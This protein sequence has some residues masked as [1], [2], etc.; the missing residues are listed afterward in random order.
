MQ[1]FPRLVLKRLQ[2][3]SLY[4]QPSLRNQTNHLFLVTFKQALHLLGQFCSLFCQSSHS[5]HPGIV[6]G[7][8]R[9]YFYGKTGQQKYPILCP[10]PALK[11]FLPIF[12]SPE[13]ILAN[14]RAHSNGPLLPCN[15]IIKRWV[16]QHVDFAFHRQAPLRM[17]STLKLPSEQGSYV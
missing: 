6:P 8:Y 12:K 4:I 7:I 10:S 15:F 3:S 5:F 16:Q 2:I 11:S 14:K 17:H 9:G 13:F 1:V